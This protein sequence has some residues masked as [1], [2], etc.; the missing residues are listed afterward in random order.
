MSRVIIEVGTHNENDQHKISLRVEDPP[1]LA[2]LGSSTL[3]LF[4][5]DPAFLALE[6]LVGD[7]PVKDAGQAIYDRI[8]QNQAIKQALSR[9]AAVGPGEVFQ[10][11]LRVTP[12]NPGDGLPWETLYL[13]EK[14]MFV[15]LDSRWP[16]ARLAG[17]VGAQGRFAP[18]S[19]PVKILAVL[20]ALD[21][22]ALPEW[23]AI[24]NAATQSGLDFRIQVLCAEEAVKD[25]IEEAADA[26]AS[27]EWVPEDPDSLIRKIKKAAPHLLHIFSHASAKGGF[28]EIAT[29][30]ALGLGD[31]GALVYLDAEHFAAASVPTWLTL[32]NACEGAQPTASG[33]SFAYA[34]TTV[35]TPAAIGMR[36]EIDATDAH[37]F[38]G[39]FYAEALDHIAQTLRTGNAEP[40][41]WAS[42]VRMARTR[43]LPHGPTATVACTSGSWTLPV[44]YLL[45]GEFVVWK[46]SPSPALSTEEARRI[47]AELRRLENTV[48]PDDAREEFKQIVAD[49]IAEL[50][51]RLGG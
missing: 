27:V 4:M 32:L 30:T 35:G 47:T 39:A 2:N 20:A 24:Y 16:M 5:D 6:D 41:D 18:L 9:M 44:L 49:R 37:L 31:P 7:Q 29:H 46:T 45:P 21:R 19:G 34:I 40:L 28:L 25:V 15:G 26:R 23:E 51:A 14:A 10:L 17:H 50:R 43:L 3:E 22:S 13:P 42:V 12:G 38:A 48:V 33:R 1:D 11:L 8:T 36:R